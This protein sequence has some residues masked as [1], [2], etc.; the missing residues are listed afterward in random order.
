MYPLKWEVGLILW[1][2]KQPSVPSV[3]SASSKAIAVL[4]LQNAGS[5]RDI[6]F[7]QLALADEIA[8]ALR[9]VSRSRFLHLPQQASTTVRI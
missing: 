7:L 1:R 3:E 4:L 5:D 9:Y 2:T 6:D 8:T